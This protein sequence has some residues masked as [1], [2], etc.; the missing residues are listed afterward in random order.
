MTVRV[1]LVDDH[2]AFRARLRALLQ[3]D[4]E[5]EIV[6]EAS[7]GQELLDLALTVEMDVST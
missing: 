2:Q 3:R 4:A 5:I 7:S 1:A 6:A